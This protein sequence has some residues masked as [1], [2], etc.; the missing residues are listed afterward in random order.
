MKT[1]LFVGRFQPFHKAHLADIKKILEECDEVIIG[2]GSSQESNTPENPFSTKERIEMIEIVLTEEGITKFTMF[3]IPDAGDDKKWVEHVIT[4][5]PEFSVV[6]SG[7]DWTIECFKKYEKKNYN[8]VKIDL[9]PG[10]NSTTVRD[11][12][13]KDEDWKS[14]V[15]EKIVEY[16]EKIDGVERVRKIN[17][18]F[19]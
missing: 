14:L 18:K 3:P 1:A 17:G 6:Y 8:V 11:R 19:N 15:P 16:I 7:N 5:V 2:I 10:I 9:I 12:I 13:I 4:L